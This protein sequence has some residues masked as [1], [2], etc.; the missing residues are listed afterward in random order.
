VNGGQVE[1]QERREQHERA[2]HLV[3]G[4]AIRKALSGTPAA[5]SELERGA[6]IAICDTYGLSRDLT[7]AGLGITL[8]HLEKLIGRR[9]MLAG[10]AYRCALAAGMREPAADLVDAVAARDVAAVAEILTELDTQGLYAL[11]VVLAEMAG[12]DPDADDAPPVSPDLA[13][14]QESPPS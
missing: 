8:A 12:R 1:A 6:V 9:R 7:A 2:V 10:F 14:E 3:D 11:A 5:L 13:R 4:V